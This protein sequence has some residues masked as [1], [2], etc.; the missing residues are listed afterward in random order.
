M[1]IYHWSAQIISRGKGQ[2]AVASAS[3][4]SGEKLTDERLDETKFYKRDVVPDTMILA[5]SHAPEWV[6]DRNRLWNEV[7]NIEKHSRSQLAREINVA[8][9]RELSKD[10]QKEM[11]K[12][13]VQE[14]F[15]DRG[16]VADVAI[17]R[18]DKNNPHAHIMLTMRPFQ[19]NGEWG[20]KKR[21]EY[22]LDQNGEKVLDK[23]GKPK[24]KTHFITDWDK[25]ESLETWREQWANHI[26]LALEKNHI[27]ER[28]SH[29]SHEDRG[30]EELPTIHLGHVVHAMEKR[31]VETARGSYNREV[32]QHNAVVIE[33]KDLRERK[34]TLLAQQPSS[35][36]NKEYQIFL[37]NEQ[38]Y[39]PGQ[40]ITLHRAEQYIK[41]KPT[42]E[43]I[44]KRFSQL[45][46]WEDRIKRNDKFH[47]WRIEAIKEV[48]KR[49]EAIDMSQKVIEQNK[50]KISNINW[51]N[52]LKVLENNQTKKSAEREISQATSRID[53]LQKE[54]QS[55]Y[56][57]LPFGS[58]KDLQEQFK[59]SNREIK[60][61][62]PKRERIGKEKEALIHAHR[63]LQEAF[64]KELASKYTHNPEIAS[65]D[66]L[67]AL[68]LNK[69][70]EIYQKVVP[71]EQLSNLQE[72]TQRLQ[73]EIEK[74]L[75]DSTN[76]K[77]LQEQLKSVNNF[78]GLIEGVLSGLQQTTP[79]QTI[80]TKNKPKNYKAELRREKTQWELEL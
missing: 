46:K 43:N 57:K 48:A 17:H 55:R 56:S 14:Q 74:D 20:N 22:L 29:L 18:D 27:P 31:G 79:S 12:K 32:Q 37:D 59:Q 80:K 45:D 8:L 70:N 65:M 72:K 6:Y 44:E 73:Q 40:L 47:Q 51:M 78:S 38:I 67:S 4:R 21:K 63:T 52:P 24:Y 69:L 71:I 10:E 60:E 15:V 3:Y 35:L 9:P 58:K 1:A 26:N 75:R 54:I 34:E 53:Q 5:P 36:K 42:L 25:K 33:L 23:K 39:S 64:V 41:E 16:M 2:S 13:Y 7:E 50:A 30:L 49:L 62:I 68:K 66:F 76:D 11:L 19:E 61:N 77:L 28:V